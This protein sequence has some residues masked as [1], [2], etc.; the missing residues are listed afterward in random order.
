ME[1][2]VGKNAGFCTGVEYTIK[3]ANELLKSGE[4]Y[5]LGEIIHNKQVIKNLENKGMKTVNNINDI[6]KGSRVI[7]RAHGEPI[8]T[9]NIAKNNNLKIEDLTCSKVRLIHQKVAEAKKDSFII[10]IGNKKHP[11]IIG[12]FGFAGENA[13]VIESEED[14]LDSYIEYEKTMLGKVYVIS[15]TTFSSKK[16][17]ELAIEIEKNFCEADVIIDKTICDSTELRQLEAREI[18]EKCNKVIV[19]GGK[20]SSN[21]KKLFEISKEKCDKVYHIEIV[22]DIKKIKFNSNDK[23]G[24]LAGASTPKEIIN[25][26]KEYIE[27]IEF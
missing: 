24:I 8:S 22:E 18:S 2:F 25:D 15:Q 14:I 6:P 7:F 10:I 3:R 17:D 16:F 21:T 5:C 19:I 23:I 13:Y 20:N 12:T 11:E 26:V 4:I 9:Y 27:G 1:I